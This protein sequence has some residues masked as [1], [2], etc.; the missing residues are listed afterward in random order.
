MLC[1]I[2]SLIL[3]AQAQTTSSSPTPAP[4]PSTPAKSAPKLGTQIFEDEDKT[5]DK[6][7]DSKLKSLTAKVKVVRDEGDGREVF[8][9]G[10]KV[11]GAFYLHRSVEHY[12]AYI[13]ILEDSKKPSGSSVTIKYDDN[14]NI[15]SVEGANASR[16][17]DPNKKWDFGE[18]PP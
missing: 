15:K 1:L 5:S 18:V 4:S 16:N 6:P 2:L 17:E 9:T 12:G 14:Q 10:E 13:K 11:S 3:N 7:A 8:F